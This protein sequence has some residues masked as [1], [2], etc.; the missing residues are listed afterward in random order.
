M[1]AEGF[2]CD[3]FRIRKKLKK[4]KEKRTQRGV[5]G[6]RWKGALR[7]LRERERDRERESFHLA[8]S[9]IFDFDAGRASSLQR[10]RFFKR[11][12][13]ERERADVA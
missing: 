6:C 11:E 7:R 2:K 4:I 12:K 10:H 3:V 1:K 9:V 5:D 8:F 13:R